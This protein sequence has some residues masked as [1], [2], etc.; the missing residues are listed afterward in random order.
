YLEEDMY[1][2]GLPLVKN[3]ILMFYLR[4]FHHRCFRISRYC[5]AFLLVSIISCTPTDL[6]WNHWGEEYSGTCR[7][8][9]VQ[10]WASVALNVMLDF[11]V[12]GLPMP[13]VAGLTPK[14]R[15]KLLLVLM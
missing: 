13:L 11:V 12:I 6:A 4:V 14:I 1:L 2:I 15:K 7:N 9:N 5:I 8:I 3:A 10:G